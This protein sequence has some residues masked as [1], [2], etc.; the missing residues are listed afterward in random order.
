MSKP[1][2]KPGWAQD[3][4]RLCTIA[5]PLPP[6]DP[7]TAP[8]PTET[9]TSG[10]TPTPDTTPLSSETPS[11]GAPFV[12]PPNVVSEPADVPSVME[13][14]LASPTTKTPTNVDGIILPR[15]TASSLYSVLSLVA[16]NFLL[17]FL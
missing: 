6:V 14:P 10:T 3:A 2:C 12:N 5:T 1:G 7:P 16:F 9:P 15:S 17:V 4:N 13:A 11:S 8:I